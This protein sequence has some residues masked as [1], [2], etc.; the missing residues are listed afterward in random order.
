MAERQTKLN[1]KKGFTLLESLKNR[2]VNRWYKTGSPLFL[3]AQ[4]RIAQRE[5]SRARRAKLAKEQVT[6]THYQRVPKGKAAPGIKFTEAKAHKDSA[7]AQTQS[8]LTKAQARQNWLAE[9]RRRGQ[10]SIS[11]IETFSVCIVTGYGDR[12]VGTDFEIEVDTSE[13]N[14]EKKIQKAL[15]S[16]LKTAGRSKSVSWNWSNDG[17]YFDKNIAPE[18]LRKGEWKHGDRYVRI[19]YDDA[20]SKG[21]TKSNYEKS[22]GGSGSG[23]M[24][25]H[26]KRGTWYASK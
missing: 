3:K 10:V 1:E 5:Q 7:E 14:V 4:R 23:P 12:E 11:N 6:V 19:H 17:A 16:K 22:W 20:N 8:I 24:S 13:G 9:E 21:K 26:N 2:S 18:L 15:R 25:K